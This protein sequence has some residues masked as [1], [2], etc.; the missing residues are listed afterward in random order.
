[1]PP[2]ASDDA[3][4]AGPSTGEIVPIEQ[5]RGPLT[6]SFTGIFMYGSAN[7]F[8]QHPVGGKQGTANADRPSF[9]AIGIDDASIFDGEIGIGFAPHQEIF[10]GAQ[11]N[12]MSGNG[13]LTKALVS[14]GVHF[15]ART[16]VHSNIRMD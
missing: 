4:D 9:E 3:G 14:D 11:Y 8:A 16:Q 5:P 1:P 12:H 15:P 7:G 2:H 6:F 13:V 10:I